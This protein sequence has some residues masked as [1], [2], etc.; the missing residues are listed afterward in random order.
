[1]DAK[2]YL[3]GKVI[4]QSYYYEL[5]KLIREYNIESKVSFLGFKENPSRYMAEADVLVLNSTSEGFGNVLIEAMTAGCPVVST[6]CPGGS[7]EIL[8][9]GEFGKLVP[10]NNHKKLAAAIINTV[11][12]KPIKKN[13]KERG[14]Y[15]NL[16]NS[17]RCYIHNVIDG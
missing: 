17:T 6:D 12:N 11:K 15:F 4:N 2:L 9:D 3:I 1:M 5:K 10:V 7:R 8:Q 14:N 13:L 16:D